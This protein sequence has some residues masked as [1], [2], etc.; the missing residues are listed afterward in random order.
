MSPGV[1]FQTKELITGLSLSIVAQRSRPRELWAQGGGRSASGHSA[2]LR[3]TTEPVSSKGL[4][5]IPAMLRL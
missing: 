5:M 2:S 3:R 1:L 4:T